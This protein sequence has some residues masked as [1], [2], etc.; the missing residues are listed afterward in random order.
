[1]YPQHNQIRCCLVFFLLLLRPSLSKKGLGLSRPEGHKSKMNTNFIKANC[2]LTVPPLMV[3]VIH[4]SYSATVNESSPQ[5][6][7]AASAHGRGGGL[8]QVKCVPEFN[9]LVGPPRRMKEAIPLCSTN[10]WQALEQTR[11]PPSGA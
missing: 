3:F 4:T 8:R 1:A 10:A 11:T 7:L 5:V 9:L 6:C 2:I